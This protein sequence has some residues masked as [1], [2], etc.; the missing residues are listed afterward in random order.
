MTSLNLHNEKLFA[1]ME[2]KCVCVFVCEVTNASCCRLQQTF[3]AGIGNRYFWTFKG[4]EL[5]GVGL[6]SMQMIRK[7]HT[8]LKYI[9]KYT[10]TNK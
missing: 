8:F 4:I 10:N 1:I 3:M 9:S 5:I 2:L 6:I 7:K